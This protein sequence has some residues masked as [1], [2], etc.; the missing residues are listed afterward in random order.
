MFIDVSELGEVEYIDVGGQ[1]ML[2]SQA[3]IIINFNHV[4]TI[5][6]SGNEIALIVRGDGHNNKL[7]YTFTSDREASKAKSA[8]LERLNK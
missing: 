3:D 8:L 1:E 7:I 2:P 6:A 4:N 5:V